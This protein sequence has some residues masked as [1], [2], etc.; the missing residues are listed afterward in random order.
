MATFNYKATNK[1]G[2][3]IKDTITA[4]SEDEAKSLLADKNLDVLVLNEKKK[5]KNLIPLSLFGKKFSAT[6]KIIICR[7]LSV[8]INSGLSLEDAFDL[9][10]EGSSNPI[11]RNVLTDISYSLRK[12]HSLYD[13]FSKYPQY[14]DSVFLSMIKAGETSGTVGESFDSLSRQLKQED[15][16]RKKVFS[17]LLYPII[18][19]VLMFAVGL[20][21][22]TFVLPRVGKVFLNLKMEIPLTTKLLLQTSLF[23]EKRILLLFVGLFIVF[24]TLFFFVKSSQGKKF[25]SFL[26]L[27]LPIIKRIYLYYSL[28]RFNQNL[29]YLLKSGVPIGESLEISS[30]TL[31]FFKNAGLIKSFNEKI[32]Q[33]VSLSNVLMETKLF[34]QLMT[35]MITVGEKTGNLDKTLIEISSFYQDEVEDSLKNFITV[36]E[37]VLMIF[38][39]IAVG[40]MI[41]TFI[42]PIYSLIGKLQPG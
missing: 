10:V 27:K 2:K 6:E 1:K 25:F 37:P 16:L 29:S 7:Y 40:F 21:M 30:R 11:V 3:L 22:F 9:I 32:S 33:G 24:I 34:P 19:V 38:V 14:F 18:I 13:G 15:T 4:S 12:G 5:K 26:V 8:T 28:V 17:S 31:T 23:V 41:L 36:L 35:S 39:G 20:I 42:S